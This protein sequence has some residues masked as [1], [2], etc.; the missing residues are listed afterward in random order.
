MDASPKVGEPPFAWP[1]HKA[2]LYR[3]EMDVVHMG[4]IIA[5]VSDRVLPIPALP[6]PAFARAKVE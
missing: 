3:V 6:N 4:G 2:V 1:V 5:I